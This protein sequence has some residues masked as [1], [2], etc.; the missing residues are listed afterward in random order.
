MDKETA[1]AFV[2]LDDLLNWIRLRSI[3]LEIQ[4]TM[5]DEL[6]ESSPVLIEEKNKLVQISQMANLDLS[7]PL[8]FE[9]LERRIQWRS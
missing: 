1:P 6:G 5:C 2:N 3:H 7:F 9:S 8:S 4:I